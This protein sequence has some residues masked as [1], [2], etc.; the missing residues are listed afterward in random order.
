M[1]CD[2]M[3]VKCE[4]PRKKGTGNNLDFSVAVLSLQINDGKIM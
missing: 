3:D 2:A 4:M 1:E